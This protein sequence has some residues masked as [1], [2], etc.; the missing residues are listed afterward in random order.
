MR[1]RYKE[2]HSFSREVK[3]IEDHVLICGYR[4]V[5]QS[6]GRLLHEQNIPYIALDLDS[7]IVKE[8]WEA[9]E[10][11]YYADAARPEILTA[12]GLYRAKIVIVTVSNME[13]AGLIVDAVRKKH[14]NVPILVRAPDD[15]YILL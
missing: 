13:I 4:R 15:T 5:G 10:S 7:R 9:G 2:A 3:E 8:A 14:A 11:V 1:Q 6:I 12:A